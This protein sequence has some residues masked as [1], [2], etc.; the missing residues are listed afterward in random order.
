MRKEE[1]EQILFRMIIKL[2]N[3]GKAQMTDMNGF[4]AGYASLLRNRL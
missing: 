4:N 3:D 1:E 2:R